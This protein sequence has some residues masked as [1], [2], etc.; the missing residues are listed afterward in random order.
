[1]RWLSSFTSRSKA[2][3]TRDLVARLF[4]KSSGEDVYTLT[5]IASQL[6]I[7]SP[8]SLASA[9]A[10]LTKEHFIDQVF[11]V[12]SPKSRGGIKDFD[13]LDDIPDEITD[14]RQGDLVIPVTPRMIRVLFR[15]HSPS[16]REV[17]T[18]SSRW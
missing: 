14:W 11:R 2:A 17:R 13:Q 9:L 3:G 8:S 10:E 16:T 5:D 18:A 12:E 6:H 1:M 15:K 4:A 7:T